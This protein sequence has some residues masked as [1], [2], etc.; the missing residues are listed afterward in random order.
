[1][2]RTNHDMQLMDADWSRPAASYCRA[3]DNG[4]LLTCVGFAVTRIRFELLQGEAR[5]LKILGHLDRIA[6]APQ[7]HQIVRGPS[8]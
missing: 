3:V 5:Q 4:R 1:M 7:K 6:G 8:I 2:K